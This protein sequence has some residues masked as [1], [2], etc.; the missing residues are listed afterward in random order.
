[1]LYK[2]K[3]IVLGGKDIGEADKIITL[4]SEERGKI[5][6]V[7]KGVRKIKSKFGSSLE[8]FT[9]SSLLVYSKNDPFRQV[10]LHRSSGKN[11][12]D[13]ISDTQIQDSFRNLRGNLAGFAYGNF[14]VELVNRMTGEGEIGGHRTFCLLRD[15]L[16][17][18]VGQKNIRVLI[19]AFTFRLFNI[20][21]YYP[22]VEKC[23]E[24]NRTVKRGSGFKFSVNRGGVLCNNCKN[25][26]TGTLPVSA[27]SVQYF[28]QLLK[29]ES[30]YL[31]N[32]RVPLNCGKELENIVQGYLDFYLE[33]NME[34]L[35]FLKNVT[36]DFTD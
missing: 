24:C 34:S 22:Q 33:R 32:L 5:R 2:V 14:L 7:A 26:E 28:K 11:S 15:F 8:T 12:L 4:Y 25:G 3:A 18:G 10:R 13:I 36:T 31:K 1:M 35:V 20:L 6:A 21:G 27:S 9:L 16:S 19:Y 17:L 23:V 29:M 30:R